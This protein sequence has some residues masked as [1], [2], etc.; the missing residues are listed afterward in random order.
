MDLLIV[1]VGVLILL[2]LIGKAKLNTFVSLAIVSFIVAML[3]GIDLA[4]I[5]TS[6][7]TGIG[8][9]LGH[10]GIIFGFGAMLGRLVS[11]AGGAYRIAHTL[12]DKFGNKRIQLAVVLASFII[13][14]ALFFEVGMVLLIPIIFAIAAELAIPILYLGIPMVAALSVA[15]G[16]LPLTLDLQPLQVFTGQIWA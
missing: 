5:P 14:I 1:L 8:G 7:E 6:I 3:L 13:G 4:K 10:L 2:F 11:D 12:I 16:F 15:H 9:Q